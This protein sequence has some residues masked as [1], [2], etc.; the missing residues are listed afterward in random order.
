MDD[1]R[2][3]RID[4]EIQACRRRLSKL[5]HE[6]ERHF[7]DDQPVSPEVTAAIKDIVNRGDELARLRAMRSGTADA[8]RAFSAPTDEEHQHLED[9]EAGITRLRK[10]FETDPHRTERH[11]IDG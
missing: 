10:L 7:I 8:N 9:L 3:A 5:R 6:G 1:D 11:F 2:L 4:A